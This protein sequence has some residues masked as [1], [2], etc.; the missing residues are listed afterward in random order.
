MELLS[1]FFSYGQLQ[2]L[3]I[4]NVLGELHSVVQKKIDCIF[5]MDQSRLKKNK[6]IL[7][8]VLKKQIVNLGL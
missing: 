5:Y 7:L 8:R 1:L 6:Q 3:L 2:N 4:D